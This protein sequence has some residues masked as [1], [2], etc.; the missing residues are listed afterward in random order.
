MEN[1]DGPSASFSF[2]KG[3]NIFGGHVPFEEGLQDRRVNR[4]P[5]WIREWGWQ[6]QDNL[7]LI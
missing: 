4:F 7:G 6:E 3:G 1:S 5:Q 2:K